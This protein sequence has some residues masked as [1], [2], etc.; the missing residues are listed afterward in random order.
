MENTLKQ[1]EKA[2]T[3]LP[4]RG[5]KFTGHIINQ[6]LDV[7]NEDVIQKIFLKCYNIKHSGDEIIRN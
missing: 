3:K 2:F 1:Y 5:P 7:L 6:N 4:K